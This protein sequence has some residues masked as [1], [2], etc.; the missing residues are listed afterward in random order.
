VGD[1][2]TGI[3]KEIRISTYQW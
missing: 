2:Y 1:T 3:L